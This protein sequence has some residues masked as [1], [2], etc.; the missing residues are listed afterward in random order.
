MTGYTGKYVFY[1]TRDSYIATLRLS[2]F[3]LVGC[4]SPKVSRVWPRRAAQLAMNRANWHLCFKRAYRDAD[5]WLSG[6]SSSFFQGHFPDK[7]YGFGSGRAIGGWGT[8]VVGDTRLQCL[9]P[10]CHLTHNHLTENDFLKRGQVVRS[11][12]QNVIGPY[13][14]ITY[15]FQLLL[16]YSTS[17]LWNCGSLFLIF[18][19]LLVYTK[20][21][22]LI[23]YP[24]SFR[25]S[26]ILPVPIPELNF[27]SSLSLGLPTLQVWMP[28]MQGCLLR[29]VKIGA[30]LVPLSVG[31]W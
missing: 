26:I 17:F 23:W 28:I 25:Y 14:L 6:C 2:G 20:G 29:V 7:W 16:K 15:F 11:K 27:S 3:L 5:T 19:V 21:F 13:L 30:P 4:S 10:H 31:M 24:I 12:D 1:R 9:L 22:F 8:A 18:S